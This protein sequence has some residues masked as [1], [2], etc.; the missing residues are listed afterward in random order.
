[1]DK[2][3]AIYNAKTLSSASKPAI[4]IAT[5]KDKRYFEL[6]HNSKPLPHGKFFL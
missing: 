2:N 3:L 6:S 1:V 5:K 4:F